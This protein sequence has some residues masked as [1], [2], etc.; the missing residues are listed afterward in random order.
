M[1]A[2][3]CAAELRGRGASDVELV[4]G[5][6]DGPDLVLTVSGM[7]SF[8]LAVLVCG[9]GFTLGPLTWPGKAG[10]WNCA[11]LRLQANMPFLD[12]GEARAGNPARAG[13]MAATAALEA[14]A[15][16]PSAHGL[17]QHLL[18]VDGVTGAVSRHRVLPAP[19][20]GVCGGPPVHHGTDAAEPPGSEVETL[21][22]L[23]DLVDGRTGVINAVVIE[24][25]EALGLDAP[26]VSTAVTACAPDGAQPPTPMP[27]G[28]GKG[29]TPATA[30][31]GAAGEALERYAASLPDPRRVIWA[32]LDELPDGE[33]ADPRLFP[34]Y[35]AAQYARPGFP[36]P[37]FDLQIAHPWVRGWR[38]A[39][40]AP[41]WIP[42][43][44]TFLDFTY[45]RPQAFCGGTSNGLAT[46]TRVADA[47]VRA[48]LELVERDAVMAAW[49]TRSPGQAVTVDAAWDEDLLGV[50]QGLERLGAAVEVSLLPSACGYP[51]AMALAF[52]DGR[53]WPGVTLGLGADPDARLAIRQA[54][55]EL[56]QTGPYLRRLMR[57][58]AAIPE[59]PEAVCEMMDHAVFY[60]DPRR[61]A[62]FDDL[63]GGGPGLSWRDLWAG[64]P[65]TLEGCVGALEA[66]GVRVWLA[67]VTSADLAMT[68]FRVVRAVSPDLQPISFGFGLDRASTT[69]IAARAADLPADYVSPIW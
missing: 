39:T 17:A 38:P 64:P 59:G 58:G 24:S 52:G 20:C 11:A 3:A 33:V 4:V 28:W 7:G 26:I 49:R 45:S 14:L 61:A 56:G 46:G 51:V 47:A 41:A 68:P 53:D 2:E 32:R 42:A 29:L 55:L 34:L 66:A 13:R 15:A 50:L 65:R 16:G 57:Q 27:V 69:R 5:D 43:A 35:D 12:P 9:D 19:R 54:V 8:A 63:R 18:R 60:F 67:D 22:A 1:V 62:A 23:A 36:F 30:M 25:G 48:L 21:R 10:C 44:F 37:P 40:G 6:S 31:I